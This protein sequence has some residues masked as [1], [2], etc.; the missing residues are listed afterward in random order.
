MLPHT[1]RL[2]AP[3]RK[4]RFMHSLHYTILTIPPSIRVCN[5]NEHIKNEHYR[6]KDHT[7]FILHEKKYTEQKRK[8]SRS[9]KSVSE[10]SSEAE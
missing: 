8:C 9:T 4:H 5:G 7:K 3:R 1:L 6:E 2:A 10:A